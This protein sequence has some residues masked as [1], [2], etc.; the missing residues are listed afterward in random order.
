MQ[1]GAGNG[2]REKILTLVLLA[3]PDLGP[4]HLLCA[5][6]KRCPPRAAPLARAPRASASHVSLMHRK[7]LINKR[8]LS[9]KHSVPHTMQVPGLSLSVPVI[10]GLRRHSQ[11]PVSMASGS[12][13]TRGLGGPRWYAS[14]RPPRDCAPLISPRSRLLVVDPF[15]RALHLLHPR[16]EGDA[17]R[18]YAPRPVVVV[19]LRLQRRKPRALWLTGRQECRGESG[20]AM[21]CARAACLPLLHVSEP[22]TSYQPCGPG[23]G[24]DRQKKENK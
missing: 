6:V 5:G 3:R 24:Q 22:R 10:H 16:P 4:L 23:P 7:P 11:G 15:G 19:V 14:V 18:T 2:C 21:L 8:S 1:S 20:D 17:G 9:H 13:W 12:A